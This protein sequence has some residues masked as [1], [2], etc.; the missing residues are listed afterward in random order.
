MNVPGI[1]LQNHIDDVDSEAYAMAIAKELDKPAVVRA[2]AATRILKE[3][4]LVTLWPEK[5]LVYKGVVI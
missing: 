5:A 1:I 2:D 4:Q 3:G